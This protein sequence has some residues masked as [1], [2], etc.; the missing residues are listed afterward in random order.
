[1]RILLT[2]GRGDGFGVVGEI[3]VGAGVTG[4]DTHLGN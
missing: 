3:V 2:V 1:M 4:G